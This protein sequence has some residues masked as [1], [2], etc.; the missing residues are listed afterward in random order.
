MNLSL[1]MR[2]GS[3]E[4]KTSF[5]HVLH[6]GCHLLTS[7]DLDLG[8]VFLPSDELIKKNP[9]QIYPASWSLVKSRLSPGV[10]S[11]ATK[12]SHYT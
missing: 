6:I 5:F 8:W 11:L 12:N 9:L 4:A 1:R 7:K 3:T 2:A 10:V